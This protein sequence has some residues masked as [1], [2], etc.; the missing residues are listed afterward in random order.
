ML[1]GTSRQCLPIAAT[2][3]SAIEILHFMTIWL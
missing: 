3:A 2:E 1:Y